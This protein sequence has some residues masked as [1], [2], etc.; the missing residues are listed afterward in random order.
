M[1]IPFSHADILNSVKTLLLA[2]LITLINLGIKNRSGCRDVSYG[3]KMRKHELL[4]IVQTHLCFIESVCQEHEQTRALQMYLVSCT[5]LQAC[6]VNCLTYNVCIC[7]YFHT[8]FRDLNFILLVNKDFLPSVIPS[9]HTMQT[10]EFG[11][12]L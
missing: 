5:V 3:E 10:F 4:H 12:T 11:V 7:N 9:L 2:I 6:C 8:I 1:I